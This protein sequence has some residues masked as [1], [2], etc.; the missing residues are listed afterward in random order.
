MTSRSL[1]AAFRFCAIGLVA[2]SILSAQVRYTDQLGAW[3]HAQD[4]AR[5]AGRIISGTSQYTDR[6]AVIGSQAFSN[7][8]FS[9]NFPDGLTI[10]ERWPRLVVSSA[11]KST[12]MFMVEDHGIIP[13]GCAAVHDRVLSDYFQTLDDPRNWS[14]VD[15][16][17]DYR[18]IGSVVTTR[19]ERSGASM[20]MLTS[21]TICSGSRGLSIFTTGGRATSKE[22]HDSILGSLQI[23]GQ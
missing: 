13:G 8:L 11:S 17:T 10:V 9:F 12:G 3:S 4:L 18:Q 21:T 6:S 1:F 2:L 7:A 16:N 14:R 15:R 22:L 5:S 20:W 19:F 23:K